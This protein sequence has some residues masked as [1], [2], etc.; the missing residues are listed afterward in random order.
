MPS[1]L[2]Y[3]GNYAFN[4][5]T[6]R[7]QISKLPDGV[8]YIGNSAFSNNNILGLKELPANLETLGSSAFYRSNVSISVLP[9][10]ITAIKSSTFYYCTSSLFK[11]LTVLGNLTSIESQAFA[12]CT[13]FEKLALPNVT[14]VPTLANKNAF[15]GTKIAKGT[16]YIY[17]PD[18]L[19]ETAKSASNWSTYASV[20]LPISQ[21]PTE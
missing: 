17:F 3:I 15:E 18:D 5:C 16:G 4:S 13:Y 8:T 19:V 6:D 10:K 11:G 9:S 21:M 1:S 12:Y 7:L 2:Q 14:A 20:I